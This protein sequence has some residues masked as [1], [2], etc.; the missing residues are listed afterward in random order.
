MSGLGQASE[1]PGIFV[2]DFYSSSKM[3]LPFNEGYLRILR[4]AYPGDVIHF[5]ADA[6]HVAHLRLA[7]A[8]VD[9]RLVALVRPQVPF[10]LSSHN[11]IGGWW[12]GRRSLKLM[13]AAITGPVRLVAVLG[14][15]AGLYG[16][17]TQHWRAESSPVD[18]I[19]HGS[20]AANYV[21]RSRNP[22]IRG[23]DLRSLLRHPIAP[24]LRLV[25]LELGVDA[26]LVADFPALAP[27]VAVLEHPVLE[28]EWSDTP[29][30][31]AGTV[32]IGFLGYGSVR[33]GFDV[34][35]R[36][37]KQSKNSALVF[38]GIG[39]EDPV[40]GLVTS[41]LR[42]KLAAISIDRDTY[43]QGL[44]GLDLVCLP[45]HGRSYEFAASG[46]VSDAVAALKPI[47][48]FRNRT[49]Q[50]I[51]D[52]YGPVG[53]LFSDADEMAGYLR[54]LTRSQFEHECRI[55][56]ENLRRMRAA[57]RPEALGETYRKSPHP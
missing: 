18:M 33:K 55:W 19:L 32:A 56:V 48:A 14:V 40:P 47:L 30:S 27:S 10:G 36:L 52:R 21:W 22:F 23:W 45:L 3:H 12:T 37:A 57:R 28:R 26:A 9:I 46:T 17:I 38:D 42:R 7:L 50:A 44:R 54:T 4:Q 39:H 25:G 1:K 35:A 49:L 6:A 8:D 24:G 43:L 41:G 2:F 11:P 34:F 31:T 13:R 29:I 16:A 51:W 15:G 20:L 5:H 53:R